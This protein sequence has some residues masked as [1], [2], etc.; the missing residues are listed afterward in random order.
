VSEVPAGAQLGVDGFTID[1]P[2]ERF[3][4]FSSWTL[5][6]W[7]ALVW[8]VLGL[9]VAA[10]TLLPAILTSVLLSSVPVI[11]FVGWIPLWFALDH[12]QSRVRTRSLVATSQGLT[13]DGRTV[14]WEAVAGL[15][16]LDGALVVE[17]QDD[18]AILLP[19]RAWPEET[20]AW[21]LDRLDELRARYTFEGDVPASVRRL[22]EQHRA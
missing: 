21:T 7:F 20:L 11:L 2:G 6:F 8:V 13:L 14:R 3:G 19:V 17:L 5:V 22:T 4:W 15:G 12:A 16:E 1:V 9:G 18:H 10:A